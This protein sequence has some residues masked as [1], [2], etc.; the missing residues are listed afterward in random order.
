MHSQLPTLGSRRVGLGPRP[1]RRAI[2]GTHEAPS[3]VANVS[4]GGSDSG[5]HAQGQGGDATVSGTTLLVSIHGK[6]DYGLQMGISGDATEFGNWK[7][8]Q[9]PPFEFE[10]QPPVNT[11]LRQAVKGQESAYVQIGWRMGG[12]RGAL[13]SVE[14][15]FEVA[16]KIR[17]WLAECPALRSVPLRADR[18]ACLVPAMPG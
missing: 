6:L 7:P 16:G 1:S 18:P 12:C 2:A 10:Q 4:T 17:G 11:P 8:A 14:I 15:E 13:V 5:A 3:H 9:F